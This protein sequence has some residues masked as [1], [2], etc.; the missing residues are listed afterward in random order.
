MDK[1][2]KN[3]LDFWKKMDKILK[4]MVK[5]IEKMVKILKKNG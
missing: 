1:L 2:L 3:W 5:I 4:K